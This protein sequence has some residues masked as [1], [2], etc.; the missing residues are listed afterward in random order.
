MIERIKYAKALWDVGL[1][2][3]RGLIAA[4]I[5]SFCGLSVL[6]ALLPG[7]LP[8]FLQPYHG[9]LVEIGKIAT[10]VGYVAGA[11]AAQSKA[12]IPKVPVTGIPSLLDDESDR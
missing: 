7:M 5:S 10:L 12:P 11:V 4:A 1:Y 9:L 2:E 6:A 8:A 3:K